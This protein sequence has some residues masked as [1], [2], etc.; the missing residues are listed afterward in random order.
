[1]LYLTLA[2]S[3]HT[4]VIEKGASESQLYR[5]TASIT[6]PYAIS[7]KLCLRICHNI[8]AKTTCFTFTFTNFSKSPPFPPAKSNTTFPSLQYL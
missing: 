5:D 2:Q 7:N 6:E 3:V 4:K 1:M 8:P